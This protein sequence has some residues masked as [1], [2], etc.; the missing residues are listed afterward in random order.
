MSIVETWRV[1]IGVAVSTSN[2]LI[3]MLKGAPLVRFAGANLPYVS[4]CRYLGIT[5]SERMSF[6]MHV[7]SLR[8]RMTGVVG[9]LARVLRA[10]WGFSPRARRT[11]Y[12]GLMVPCALF[13]ASVWYAFTARQI[14]ARRRLIACQRL[15]LLGC[16]PVCRTVSTM[17]LQ[18]LAISAD[19]TADE[20]T[21]A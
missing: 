21:F 3:M 11:I 7:A 1:I 2:T 8:E 15:I 6:L 13:G 10:D 16:L 4:S 5:V 12:A 20:T 19:A 14:V 9:A 18:V 17:A